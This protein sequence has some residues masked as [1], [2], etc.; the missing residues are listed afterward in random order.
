[1]QVMQVMQPWF[2]GTPLILDIHVMVNCNIA[3]SCLELVEVTCF[4]KL[5]ADEVLGF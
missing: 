1:M 3:G 2:T 5:A 4:L